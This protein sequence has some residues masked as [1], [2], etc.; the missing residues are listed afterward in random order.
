[1][2]TPP[3][4]GVEGPPATLGVAGLIHDGPIYGVDQAAL[5]GDGLSG[6]GVVGTTGRAAGLELGRHDLLYVLA[7][8]ND[9][10]F[11]FTQVRTMRNAELF[12]SHHD[13]YYTANILRRVWILILVLDTL[14]T[15]VASRGSASTSAHTLALPSWSCMIDCS[16]EGSGET[17]SW[18][19]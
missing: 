18:P 14:G 1:M 4:L 16:T 10:P 2:A 13:Y 3:P 17:P 9:G 5:E 12:E 6:R 7:T 15:C 11:E 19:T 8:T